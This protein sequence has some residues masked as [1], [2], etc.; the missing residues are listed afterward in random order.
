[1]RHSKSSF[2]VALSILAG[3]AWAQD[4]AATVPES[5]PESAPAPRADS[6]PIA[7]VLK[8]TR[9][10]MGR[11]IETQQIISKERRDW[12]QGKDILAGR[13]ELV[14]QEVAALDL[15]IKEA[16]KSVAEADQKKQAL[17]AENEQLKATAA[18]LAIAVGGLEAEIRKLH[19]RLPDF[20]R[21]KLQPLFQRIPEDP[22]N[23]KV[24]IAERYQN[25]LGI[26]NEIN[27]T[28]SE[29]TVNYEV[30]TLASG[31]PSEVKAIYVGL[32]QAYYVS[33]QGEAGIGRPA[34]DGWKW[35]PSKSVGQDVL[36]ALDILQGKHSA[37]FVPLPVKIQ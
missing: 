7:L 3:F 36:M 5:R 26:L 15:K 11:W 19:K 1:M 34:D 12:Q 6:R 20:V 23:T 17:V 18:H 10:T 4:G 24:S 29:I 14:K 35:E 31:K 21:T 30:H 32:A 9:Q 27:K 22:A 25:V 37:A 13:V 28:N 33:A 8:D 16:E 2:L